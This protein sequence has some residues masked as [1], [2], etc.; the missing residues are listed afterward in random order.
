MP[1]SVHKTKKAMFDKAR[2]LE[3]Q[4]KSIKFDQVTT[5][6]LKQNKPVGKRK[7]EYIL[8]WK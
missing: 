2:V 5:Q 7:T 1:R 8:I 6:K 3:A 4:G